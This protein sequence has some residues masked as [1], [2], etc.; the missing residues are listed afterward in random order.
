MVRS[1]TTRPPSSVNF[2]GRLLLG[3]FDRALEQVGL[4]RS[5]LC[6]VEALALARAKHSE[7][8]AKGQQAAADLHV[9]PRTE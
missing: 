8:V 9:G 2:D 6:G 7:L 1:S 4:D 5:A 3:G